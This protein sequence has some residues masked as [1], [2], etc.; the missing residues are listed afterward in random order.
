MILPYCVD[1]PFDRR[2]WANWIIIAATCLVSVTC[3]L[4]QGLFDALALGRR[5]VPAYMR[6]LLRI[7]PERLESYP[8][9]FDPHTYVTY[10]FVHAGLLQLAANMYFLFF[11]GNAVNCKLGHVGYT[12]AYL[13]LAVGAAA[14]HVL[15]R[16]VPA[17]GASGAICGVLG[18]FAVLFP[19]IRIPLS[20]CAQL[21]AS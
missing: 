2:P 3:L 19:L 21:G 6:P 11:F 4:D 8:T 10:A 17:A 15:T 12:L 13:A 5:D 18:L 9:K 7:R 20:L 14:I 1:V 16:G